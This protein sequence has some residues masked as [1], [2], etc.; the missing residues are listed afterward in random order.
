M[1]KRV[2]DLGVKECLVDIYG[3]GRPRDIS[4]ESRAWLVSLA[5]MK[6]MDFCYPH[7]IWT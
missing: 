2:L 7:E 5:C 4:A 6:P 3:G 1:D